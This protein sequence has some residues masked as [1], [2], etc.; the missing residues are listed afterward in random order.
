MYVDE[1]P[2][3]DS[4]SEPRVKDYMSS[5]KLKSPTSPLAGSVSSGNMWEE[6]DAIKRRLRQLELGR[7]IP[8]GGGDRPHTRGTTNSSSSPQRSS[9]FPSQTGTSIT[10]ASSPPSYP[11]LNSA[12][13]KVKASGLSL[14][15][16]QAIEA[17]AQEAISLA[18]M[19]NPDPS[20]QPPSPRAIRRKVDGV[21]RGL[22]EV[23]LAIADHQQLSQRQ[24]TRAA[25]HR[26]E[27][28]QDSSP[29]SAT[30]RQ[31]MTLS[32]TTARRVSGGSTVSRNASNTTVSRARRPVHSVVGIPTED[33]DDDRISTISRPG[34]SR[35]ST[36]QYRPPSRAA[37][38]VFRETTP[39]IS[40]V[41]RFSSTNRRSLLSRHGPSLSDYQVRPP[42]SSDNDSPREEPP[43]PTRATT[44]TDR[45]RSLNLPSY[46]SS[47]PRTRTEYV[48][49]S[50][51]PT[52]PSRPVS[53][54]SPPRVNVGQ[55]SPLNNSD[56]RDGTIR[57]RAVASVVGAEKLYATDIDDDVRSTTL[58]RSASKRR[59]IVGTGDLRRNGSVTAR[60]AREDQ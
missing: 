49:D 30:G 39:P 25:Q 20:S 31:S 42:T 41:Q 43:L 36:I 60:Y 50:G 52:P 55:N 18:L 26:A 33:F 47:P 8:G 27:D 6:L 3:Q 15:I 48:R 11:L 28:A 1:T 22:T 51:L 21:C 9:P 29:L 56:R 59:S 13:T 57:R 34:L 4:V 14:D 38:E 32:R 19:T 2:T 37:T 35:L 44:M 46:L 7:P 10:S 58:E 45:R 16:A 12:I 24:L 54:I 17:T 53:L 23:C 5:R 40:T